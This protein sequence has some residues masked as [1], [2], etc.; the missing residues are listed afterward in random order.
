MRNLSSLWRLLYIHD[1]LD[2]LRYMFF[3]KKNILNW[4]CNVKFFVYLPWTRLFTCAITFSP[5]APAFP[6]CRACFGGTTFAFGSFTEAPWLTDCTIYTSSF[7]L[8]RSSTAGNRT[9]REFSPLSP[10]A[11]TWWDLR[12]LLLLLVRAFTIH[13]A[14]STT[15]AYSRS[16]AQSGSSTCYGAVAPWTPISP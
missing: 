11:L 12:A 3:R 13:S 9:F 2:F 14:W 15:I 6:F 10:R 8:P 5:F 16:R 4:L 1:F 7:S